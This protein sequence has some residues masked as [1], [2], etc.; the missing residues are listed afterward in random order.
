MRALF[1]LFGLVACGS[2]SEQMD[3]SVPDAGD[4]PPQHRVMMVVQNSFSMGAADPDNRRT[5]LVEEAFAWLPEESRIGMLV[6]SDGWREAGFVA[7]VED[8][9]IQFLLRRMEMPENLGALDGAMRR[10]KEMLIQAR[11]AEPDPT[12]VWSMVIVTDGF[13]TPSCTVNQ[14]ISP[15]C[16]S[17]REEWGMFGFD[18]SD[19]SLFYGYQG[20]GGAY[21]QRPD[22]IAR[23]EET[24][25]FARVHVI[26]QYSESIVGQPAETSLGL[27]R[28]ECAAF[29]A[30]LAQA[31]GGNVVVD[32]NAAVDWDALLE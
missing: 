15:I 3:A 6:F 4:A 28:V 27:N 30:L 11:D 12:L 29:A 10:A 2:E 13:P 17:P 16:E 20:A 9:Q 1:L 23:A 21:N 18:V 7:D 22:A 24:L 19:P 25:P 5:T 26:L 32:D 14:D 31:G 8:A